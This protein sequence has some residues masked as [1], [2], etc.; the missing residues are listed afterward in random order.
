LTVLSLL[1]D[2]STRTSATWKVQLVGLVVDADTIQ[3]KGLT[4]SFNTVDALKQ[5]L[6]VSPNVKEVTISSATL[7]RQN[8]VAFE[9][10]MR[11]A[12]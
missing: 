4:D 5:E 12:W 7:D 8:S 3:I 1:H 6:A 2:L 11:K 9:L 10:R